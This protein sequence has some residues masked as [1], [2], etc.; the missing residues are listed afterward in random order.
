MQRRELLHAGRGG[1][2]GARSTVATAPRPRARDKRGDTETILRGER[3]E[4]SQAGCE[5]LGARG[6]STTVDTTGTSTSSPDGY[7]SGAAVA[8]GGADGRHAPA[9]DSGRRWMKRPAAVTPEPRPRKA[10]ASPSSPLVLAFGGALRRRLLR[11][12][13]RGSSARVRRASR[14][15]ARRGRSNRDRGVPELFRRAVVVEAG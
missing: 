7:A 13:H 3:G 10:R 2:C 8:G 15:A 5:R 11:R 1:S 12:S 14:L 6:V 4:T 9:D